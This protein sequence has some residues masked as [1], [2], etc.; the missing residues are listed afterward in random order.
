MAA[1]ESSIGRPPPIKFP[2]GICF[3]VPTEPVVHDL[4]VGCAVSGFQILT[5]GRAKIDPQDLFR[6]SRAA[7]GGSLPGKSAP[8]FLLTIDHS[9]SGAYPR[10]TAEV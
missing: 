10:A 6:P 3:R 7:S 4:R 2:Q 5:Q 9:A 8:G 1:L